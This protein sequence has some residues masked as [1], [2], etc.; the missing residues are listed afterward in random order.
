MSRILLVEDDTSLG[1][2]LQ[3]RLVRE[4]YEVLWAQSAK[5]AQELFESS[6]FDLGIL[7]VGLPDHSGFELATWLKQRSS[8]PFIFMTAMSTAEYRLQ[9]FEIG[10]EEYIPKPFHLKEILMR[11]KHVLEQHP[12]KRFATLGDSK[13]DFASLNVARADG[14]EVRMA[15]RDAQIL[16]LLSDRA[17]EVVSREEILN[18]FWGEDKF[19][20]ERTV[21]NCILRLR[22]AIADEG[23]EVIRSV[24]G[25]GYQL[26]KRQ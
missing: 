25:V 10:A 23:G 13:V 14:S 1:A 7:D 26:E 20:S 12:V 24:R 16:K 21:D 2:T 15:A 9:G 17:P 3:E 5:Q 4:G 8:M 19:P 18:R 6:M 22:Q 11:V